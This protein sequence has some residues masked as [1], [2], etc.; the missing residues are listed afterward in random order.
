MSVLKKKLNQSVRK[1]IIKK[2]EEPQRLLMKY[3][4]RRHQ[5]SGCE[6]SSREELGQ[7]EVEKKLFM[8]AENKAARVS[9]R[10]LNLK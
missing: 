3:R 4:R 9:R 10:C 1:L 2:F 8:L 6:E 7:R 5:N